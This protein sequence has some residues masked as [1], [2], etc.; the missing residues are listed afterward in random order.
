MV[1][2]ASDHEPHGGGD[3]LGSVIGLCRR[4]GFDIPAGAP[5]CPGCGPEL[6]VAPS[7]AARQVAGL[8]LPT[9]SVRPLPR[10]PPQRCPEPR[11]V[12]PAVGAR[13]AFAYTWLLVVVA[14]VGAL[15]AWV[16]RLDRYVSELP[17][18][19]ADWLDALTVNATIGAIIGLVVGFLAILV[20]CVRRVAIA[21]ARRQR[22]RA[23]T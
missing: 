13:A 18:G 20:W 11:E 15:L 12:P 23:L 10:T 19:T 1:R 6:P 4:C 21:I 22:R 8:A 5:C 3:A 9:R 17:D 16:A 14:L 7:L 2:V